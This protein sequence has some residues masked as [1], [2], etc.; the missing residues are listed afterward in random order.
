M[1]IKLIHYVD[2][3]VGGVD[4][5]LAFYLAVLGP[6][7]MQE[8][9]RYPS[10]RGTEEVVYLR[11]GEQLLGFRQADGGEH[12]YYEVGLE[13]LALV[14]DTRQEVED[15]YARCLELGVKVHFPPEEDRD[16]PGYWGCSSSTP[17]A[18]PSRSRTSRPRRSRAPDLRGRGSRPQG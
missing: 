7:G 17:T 9:C 11:A 15:T 18:C 3:A 13:H 4:R 12:R 10:Y 8:E 1:P 16:L 14:V 6:L 2:L 5:T